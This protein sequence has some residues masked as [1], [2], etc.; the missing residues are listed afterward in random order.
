MGMDGLF[1]FADLL[2]MN[3]GTFVDQPPDNR[4]HSALAG[5]QYWC[6]TCLSKRA[7]VSEEMNGPKGKTR[8]P[9]GEP[10]STPSLIIQDFCYPVLIN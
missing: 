6:S 4:H 9:V 5:G 8:P 1:I 3:R 2:R 7:R 10:R